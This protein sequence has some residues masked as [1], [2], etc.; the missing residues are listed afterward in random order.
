MKL[1]FDIPHENSCFVIQFYKL[2]MVRKLPTYLYLL[3]VSML[4]NMTQFTKILITEKRFSI[5]SQ[6]SH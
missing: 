1:S 3:I 5:S 6:L 2:L 4:S